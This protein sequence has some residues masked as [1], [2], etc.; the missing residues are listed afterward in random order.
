MFG[1]DADVGFREQGYLI[2]AAPEAQALLAENVALQQSMGAD[3]ALLEAPSWRGTF[4]WLATE[5]VAAAGFGR[6][7]RGLVRSAEPRRAVAQCGAA[8]RASPSCMIA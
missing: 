5:G 6:I 7:G 2:M 3:I 1:A 4:P 8:A